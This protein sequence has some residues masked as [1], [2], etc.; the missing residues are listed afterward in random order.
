MSFESDL[1][2]NLRTITT[3][4]AITA[5]KG[6][7]KPFIIYRKAA[8]S[9]QYSHDG[10]ESLTQDRVT[11]HYYSTSK[12]NARL[13]IKEVQ[14][15]MDGWSDAQASLRDTREGDYVDGVRLFWESVDYVIWHEG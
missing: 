6:V 12:N 3:T 11:I 7:T 8:A 10:Y 4:Y 13:G 1:Y 2:D 9:R 15:A 5:P 14:T